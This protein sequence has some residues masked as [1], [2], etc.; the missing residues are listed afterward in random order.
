MK[1]FRFLHTADLHLDSPFRGLA[2]LPPVIRDRL[3]DS[4]FAALERMVR[5]AAEQQA[6][7]VV[8]AGD[9][10]DTADRSLKA[11]IR[12]QKAME[13]LAGKQIPAFIVHGNHDPLKGKSARLRY[14]DSVYFFSG[15]A[16][17][18]TA[19][20]PDRGAVA[21]IFGISY[22]TA[23]VQENLALRF[24]PNPGEL[25][26][27]G[28][29]HANVDG[30]AS[31]DNYA[32]CRLN[33]L[34]D[35]GIHYWA[36]GHIHTRRTLHEH[37]HV[38]YPGNTQGR[39]SNETGAKGC[40]I[41]D[42]NHAGDTSLVFHPLDTVR[43]M[44]H[45]LSIEGM[46]TEQHLKEAVESVLEQLRSEAEGRACIVRLQ[47]EGRGKLHAAISQ[48]PALEELAAELRLQE[49][50]AAEGADGYPFVWIEAIENRT[51][52]GLD[53]SVLA[54]ETSFLGDL[55]RLSQSLAEDRER[56][57]P[58][59]EEALAALKSQP[60]LARLLRD[61]PPKERLELLKAA[62]TLAVDMLAE[63]GGSE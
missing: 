43:W 4:T 56:F 61:L 53:M 63:T 18:I 36:L 22:E 49:T 48:G 50:A 13:Q 38:V 26:R 3:R 31:H 35:R 10:Y 7:F 17:S 47:L 5:L 58:F 42:V 8:I 37:P 46:D 54:Q 55:L 11:Q 27:I 16:A 25:Y 57:E 52:A 60:A 44:R 32:P 40:Y 28:L 33:D 9:V 12:F 21:E 34:L 20:T 51:G 6:D 2:G 15:E 45:S 19:M 24:Q 14:P 29:L 30:D 1:A 23:A 59:C 62:E 39:H 41:V